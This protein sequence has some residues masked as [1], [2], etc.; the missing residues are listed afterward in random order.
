MNLNRDQPPGTYKIGGLDSG[1][2]GLY[3]NLAG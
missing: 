3:D 1:M 2:K